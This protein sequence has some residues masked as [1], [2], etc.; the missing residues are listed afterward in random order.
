MTCCQVPHLM[1]G[2][3]VRLRSPW[4]SSSLTDRPDETGELSRDRSH[5]DRWLFASGDH[6]AIAGAEPGLCLPRDVADV[7]RQADQDLSLLLRDACGILIAPCCFDQHP[8]GFAVAGLGDAAAADRPTAG[9]LGRDETEI[10]HQQTR[11][12][13]AAEIAGGGDE[14]GRGDE[15]D[16]AQSS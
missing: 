7:L 2:Q 12:L 5:D 1:S 8:S 15:V 11:R 9:V 10:A 14:G 4:R 16:A 3:T 13:E 6:G